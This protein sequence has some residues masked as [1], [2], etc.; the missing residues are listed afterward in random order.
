MIV[1]TTPTGT[2][3]RQVVENLLEQ[4][5]DVRVIARDPSR[6]SPAIRDRVEVVEGSHGDAD[7]V[8]EAFWDAEA[9][10]WVAPPNA[11]AADLKAVYLDFIGPATEVLRKQRVV[12]VSALGRG[13]PYEAKAGHVTVSLAMDDAIAATGVPYRALTMPSFMDNVLRQAQS[14]KNDGVFYSTTRPDLKAPLTATRDIAAV[15]ARLLLDD[16]WSGS[17]EVPVLG[18]EDLSSDDM[19]QIMTEVL[20]YPVRYQQL[21]TDGYYQSLIGRGMNP[22]IARGMIDMMVAKDNGLDNAVTR[23][24]E[25]STPTTFRQ[26]VEEVLKPAVQR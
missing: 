21:P 22:L 6:L 26:W 2:I 4:Q 11:Q 15:G 19:A 1:V 13:T 23:T 20:G 10:F 25:N 7:V 5:A 18:P 8:A 17:G 12:G 16:T 3:G 24:P 9:I 14:I